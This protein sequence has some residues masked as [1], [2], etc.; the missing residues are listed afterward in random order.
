MTRLLLDVNVLLDVLLDRPPHAAAAAAVWA[1]VE[2]GRAEG[3]IPAHGVTTIHY[4]AR[5]SR[6]R[7]FARET[8][9][10]LM[11]VFQVAALDE[12]SIR[13]A[14]DL[15]WNDF[16]DAVCAVVGHASGCHALVTRNPGDYAEDAPLPVV[17]P[18]AAVALIRSDGPPGAPA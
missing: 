16:E 18:A 2:E 7:A 15:D 1:E 9:G 10:D 11:S 14:V 13:R 4:L 6:G 8:I 3:L 17:G 12:S 5:R